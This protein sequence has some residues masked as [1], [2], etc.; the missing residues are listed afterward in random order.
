MGGVLE[1]LLRDAVHLRGG[2]GRGEQRSRESEEK[3][4]STVTP[5]RCQ[6]S[7]Q[8]KE[9]LLSLLFSPRHKL[10]CMSYMIMLAIQVI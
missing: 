3:F 1:L 7:V 5:C 6:V 8:G 4:H 2:E 10:K 9:L